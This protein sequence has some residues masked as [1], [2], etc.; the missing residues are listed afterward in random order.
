MKKA[1][2]VFEDGKVFFGN[3]AGAEGEAF[4]EIVYNTSVCG[5]QEILSNPSAFGKIINFSYPEVGGYGAVK[6]DMESDSVKAAGLVVKTAGNITSNWRSSE[7]FRSFLEKNKV[8]AVENIDTRAV[9]KHVVKN[10]EMK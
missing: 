5:Y 4:G 8:V 9:L 1:M 10:G 7:T 3:S 2:L 6:D